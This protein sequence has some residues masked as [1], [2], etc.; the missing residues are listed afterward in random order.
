MF[1]FLVGCLDYKAYD[2]PQE[3][4]NTDLIDEIAQIEAEL[5][6]EEQE[7]EDLVVEEDVILPELEETQSTEA[8]E[9]FVKENS[10]VRLNVD[11]TDPDQDPVTYTFT[12]PVNDRGEWQTHYGDAGEYMVTLTATDGQLTTTKQIRIIVE[13]V[14]V[15][16]VL[17]GIRDLSV[18]EGDV[19]NF[20]PTVNDPNNDAVTD[21]IS[22]PLKSGTFATDHT[23]AGEYSITVTADDGE[24]SSEETFTLTINDVNELPVLENI[25][26]TISVQEGE[27]ITIKPTISDLDGDDVSLTIS[28]PVGDD[29]VWETGFTD[30]GEYTITVTA[31]DGK[32][33]VTKHVKLTV[34]DVNMPPE[35]VSVSLQ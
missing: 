24:L 16:P 25:E 8:Q 4:E 13:R 28:Q 32:D 12:P 9:I 22:E 11:V 1:I 23:S 5:G 19:I 30:H 14:N 18:Q 31:D 33:T 20:E 10:L 15:P 6:L 27:T 29:G 17:T 3:T 26:S 34:S 35:I 21:S 2:V 7:E